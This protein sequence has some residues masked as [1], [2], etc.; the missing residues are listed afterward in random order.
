M[1]GDGGTRTQAH[2]LGP[3]REDQRTERGSAPVEPGSIWVDEVDPHV[4]RFS[5][6]VDALVLEQTC[7]LAGVDTIT[8]ARRLAADGVRE[9]ELSD[10]TFI[11]SAVLALVVSLMPALRPQRLKVRGATG[12]VLTVLTV[13]GLD[14]LVELC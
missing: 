2:R 12:P 5:G 8:L 6:D 1:S 4:L 10:T 3:G 7:A 11:D 14:A 9:L 13:T